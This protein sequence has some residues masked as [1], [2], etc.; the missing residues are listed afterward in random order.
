[1]QYANTL[2]TTFNEN[3]FLLR[4]QFQMEKDKNEVTTLVISPK[5][6]KLLAES[7]AASVAEHK[8][9]YGGKESLSNSGD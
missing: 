3:E 6:A 1:M 4:F 5:L 7:L 2:Q 8:N 9:I